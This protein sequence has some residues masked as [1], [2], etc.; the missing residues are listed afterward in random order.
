M[1]PP[2][3]RSFL[4]KLTGRCYFFL[5][6]QAY[7]H[8]SKVKFAEVV[9]DKILPRLVFKHSSPL[10]RKLRNVD[11]HLQQSKVVNLQL[12]VKKLN[13]LVIKPD[14]VF[15]Y[16]RAIGL[17]GRRKGYKPGMVL[18]NGTVRA[19]VGGGLCQLSNL[20]YWMALHTELDVVERWRHSYDVFPDSGRTLPF[21]SGATCAYPNIDLQIKNNTLNV[22]Q[23]VLKLTPTELV[24]EWRAAELPDV[25]YEVLEKEHIIRH[26]VWG[27]YTRHNL[28]ARKVFDAKTLQLLRE[29]TVT[30]NHA[31]MMYEP[32]LQNPG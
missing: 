13:G 23:L 2:K 10:F 31:I 25:F 22:F 1:N 29:E 27:K 20:I 17:P 4:R 14:Q 30:E 28:I 15:S 8:L 3:H 16:W 9:E 21:G 7:W 11:M 26:E 18:H 12:A 24:G 6:K 32:L 19:G 5:K